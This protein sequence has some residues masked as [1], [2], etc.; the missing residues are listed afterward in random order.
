MEISVTNLASLLILF[1]G[2]GFREVFWGL[3]A[4]AFL[5]VCLKALPLFGP[6][7][8]ACF[9]A[10]IGPGGAARWGRACVR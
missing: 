3:L 10:A 5:P 4:L 7:V 6:C 1:K 2:G 8:C 9:A